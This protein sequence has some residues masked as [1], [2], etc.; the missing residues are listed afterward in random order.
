M[1]LQ[2]FVNMITDCDLVGEVLGAREINIIYGESIPAENMKPVS[3]EGLAST[4]DYDMFIVAVA[5]VA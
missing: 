5:R 1:A 4:M 3:N 2:D